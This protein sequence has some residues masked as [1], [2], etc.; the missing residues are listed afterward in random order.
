[1][2]EFLALNSG[3]IGTVRI[4]EQIN[5]CCLK[6]KT[7]CFSPRVAGRKTHKQWGILIIMDELMR[8]GLQLMALGMGTVFLF[9]GLLIFVITMVS[10]IIQKFELKTEQSAGAT[11]SSHDDL[12]EVISAAVQQY[13]S[14]HPRRK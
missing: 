13:R 11:A 8:Q 10:R 1:M 14:D 4:Q 5:I 6:W 3:N 2:D 9:L 12:V 7:Q